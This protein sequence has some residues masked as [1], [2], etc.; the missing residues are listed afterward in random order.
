MEQKDNFNQTPSNEETHSYIDEILRRLALPAIIAGALIIILFGLIIHFQTAST[1]S[2]A[3]IQTPEPAETAAPTTQPTPEPTEKPIT[4]IVDAGHGGADPG[5]I[6]V[7]GTHEDV[8]N[9]QIA[10]KLVSALTE[11]GYVVIETRPDEN[12]LA[13]ANIPMT[14]TNARK[15][16]DLSNRVILIGESDADLLISIHQ[17]AVDNDPSVHKPE[18]IYDDSAP[19]EGIALAQLIQDALTAE[20]NIEKPR[21]IKDQNLAVT[22]VLPCSVLV[23]CGFISNPEEEANL[24]KPE[25]QD[26][27]VKAIIAGLENYLSANPIR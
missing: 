2:V 1:M 18:V 10:K 6:G 22:S 15:N 21:S 9:L 20:F 8:L 3:A 19:A 25:Y 13:D 14:D 5:T 7:N 26:R 16:S 17:N 11:R 27:I 4:I 23:E 12:D 24:L